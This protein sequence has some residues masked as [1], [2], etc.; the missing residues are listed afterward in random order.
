MPD[1]PPVN[2]P[3]LTLLSKAGNIG[4]AIVLLTLFGHWLDHKFHTSDIFTV[5]GAIL[6]ILYSLY[7]AWT[8]LK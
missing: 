2:R 8:A 7:E 4:I 1:K 3:D 5:A 6:G